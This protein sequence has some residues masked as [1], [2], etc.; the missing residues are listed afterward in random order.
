MV[1]MVFCFQEECRGEYNMASSSMYLGHISC[2]VRHGTGNTTTS[3]IIPEDTENHQ[4]RISVGLRANLRS[5]SYPIKT[6][7][8]STIK[9]NPQGVEVGMAEILG[10]PSA[11]RCKV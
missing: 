7:N 8:V 10:A 5:L 3:V 6:H 1:V 2:V 11:L 4:R 9:K